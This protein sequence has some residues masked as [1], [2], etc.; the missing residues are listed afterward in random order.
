MSLDQAF[1]HCPIFHTAAS[2]NEF[3]PLLSP[4]VAGHSLKPTKDR[5]LGKL[6]PHQLLNPT[7]SH[8]KAKLIF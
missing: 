8:L 6:L 5:Q 1:A 7:L 3:G 4:N 2:I